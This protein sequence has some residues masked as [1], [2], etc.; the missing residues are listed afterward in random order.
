MAVNYKAPVRDI[1][2]AYDVIDAYERLG[3]IKK[4]NGFSK[5]VV[6]PAIEECAKF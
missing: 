1:L 6:V 4:Y 5:D 2:F 3:N